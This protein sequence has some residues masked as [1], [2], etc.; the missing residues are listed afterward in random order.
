MP[1]GLVWIVLLATLAF[2]NVHTSQRLKLT[3]GCHLEA[4]LHFW[5][6]LRYEPARVSLCLE[7]HIVHVKCHSIF[8]RPLVSLNG[9]S[10]VLNLEV[11]ANDH[12]WALPT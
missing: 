5:G 3:F 1:Y 10:I 2:C 11:Y 4:L 12:S 8:R 6:V 9:F 7:Q